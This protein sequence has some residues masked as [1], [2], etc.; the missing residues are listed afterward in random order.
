MVIVCVLAAAIISGGLFHP[1]KLI[2]PFRDLSGL[3]ADVTDTG[4]AADY[5]REKLP[6]LRD[7][8][9]RMFRLLGPNE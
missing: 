6:V 4:R 1:D 2:A 9:E 3:W 7:I 8:A 5:V